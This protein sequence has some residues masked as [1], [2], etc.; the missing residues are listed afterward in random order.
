MI[1]AKAGTEI[2]DADGNLVATLTCDIVRGQSVSE[3][4]FHLADGTVPIRGELMPAAVARFV[5]NL[6]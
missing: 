6:R 2:R 5:Q 4:Q 1:L 3:T